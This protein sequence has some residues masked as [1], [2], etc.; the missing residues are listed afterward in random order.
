MVLRPQAFV[1]WMLW[2]LDYSY[3]CRVLSIELVFPLSTCPMLLN[4]LFFQPH[5]FCLLPGEVCIRFLTTWR[6]PHSVHIPAVPP[7]TWVTELSLG[8]P[9]RATALHGELC[10]D[11]SLGT[12]YMPLPLYFSIAFFHSSL[13]HDSYRPSIFSGIFSIT[14]CL[15]VST[16][17][18]NKSSLPRSYSVT[19]PDNS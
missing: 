10:L 4:S 15:Q 5:V 13:V 3:S 6:P 17:Y 9:C 14:T 2:P 12:K 19:C 7:P 8:I 11:S 18:P 1:T 16:M